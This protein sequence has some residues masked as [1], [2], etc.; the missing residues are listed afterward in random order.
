MNKFIIIDDQEFIYN[1]IKSAIFNKPEVKN[2]FDFIFKKNG[3]EGYD[4]IST[5]EQIKF[6]LVDLN[7][8]IMNGLEMLRKIH[9]ECPDKVRSTDI[10][11]ITTESD[12]ELMKEA[13]EYGVSAWIIK[14]IDVNG[15]YQVIKSKLVA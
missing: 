3:K 13:R 12:K 10:F 1:Q 11:V 4:Y 5:N 7:M 2:Q 9:L 8:P 15:L 6:I 14:P